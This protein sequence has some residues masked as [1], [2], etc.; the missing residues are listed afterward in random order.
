MIADARRCLSRGRGDETEAW[1]PQAKLSRGEDSSGVGERRAR[2]K[3]R[4]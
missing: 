3:P 2:V 1:D 4:E